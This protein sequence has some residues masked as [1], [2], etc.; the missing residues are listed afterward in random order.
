MTYRFDLSPADALEEQRRVAALVRETPLAAPPRLIAGT[1]VSFRGD[2]AHAVVTVLDAE[3]LETVET[4][5]YTGETPFPYIPGLFSFR[6]IPVLLP[7]FERLRVRPDVV[8]CDGQGRAHPRR[9]GLACHL[10]VVLD[11]PAFGVA[12]S[13]LVGRYEAL[14]EA[15]GST[16][17]LVHRKETVGVALRTRERILPVFVSTGHRITLDEAIALTMQTTTRF[18]IPEPT[19]RAHAVSYAAGRE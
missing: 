10:G 13:L 8:M 11:V 12:K 16:A 7:A 9:V 19:R 3:T 15:K 2:V 5:T 4:A 14:G 18:K 6:E 1:D 17:P